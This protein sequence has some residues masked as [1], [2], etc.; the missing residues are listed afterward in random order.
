MGH[1]QDDTDNELTVSEIYE[2]IDLD[3]NVY[4]RE[5]EGKITATVGKDQGNLIG[6]I[7]S[8][9][10]TTLSSEDSAFEVGTKRNGTKRIEPLQ[11][12]RYFRLMRAFLDSFSADY[13]YSEQ[14][15]LFFDC[16]K[17]LELDREEMNFG[18]GPAWPSFHA[19]KNMA[20][21]FEDLIAQMR[22]KSKKSEFKK[23]VRARGY[24]SMRN[25]E[26]AKR[27]DEALFRKYSRLMVV[28][29]DFGYL[30]EH[31]QSMS[32][33][34]ASKDFEH[35]LNNQRCK[36]TLF[37]AL[38]GHIAKLEWGQD[39][40]YHFHLILYFDGSQV[41]K[42]SYLA[43]EIGMYWKGITAGRGIFF[44]CNACKNKYKRLGIGMISHDDREARNNLLLAIRY[45][46][47]KEQYLQ[48]IK[49]GRNSRVFRRGVTPSARTSRAG[50]PR[51]EVKNDK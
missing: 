42:D 44:N 24:N 45:I 8:F 32:A 2:G 11:L 23:R 50:R 26:S 14:V 17:E 19:G 31:A 29:I 10:E 27:Y 40:K 41:H 49:I 25:Y 3:T 36:P 21:R 37:H 33:E 18:I 51:K 16:C 43:N 48:A 34:E 13:R 20:D 9:V 46:T 1:I 12:G 4:E 22:A 38:V 35:F 30:Q 7:H 39:K 15:G 47:K 5:V 6:S 28:R